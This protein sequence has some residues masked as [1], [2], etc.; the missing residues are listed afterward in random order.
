MPALCLAPWL[1][2]AVRGGTPPPFN[3]IPLTV[4]VLLAT[5]MQRAML[6]PSVTLEAPEEWGSSDPS[7]STTSRPAAVSQGPGLKHHCC[8]TVEPKGSSLRHRKWQ[9][10]PQPLHGLFLLTPNPFI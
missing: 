6:R 8:P 4:V 10:M 3:C 7:W 2:G 1:R 5:Y 9:V